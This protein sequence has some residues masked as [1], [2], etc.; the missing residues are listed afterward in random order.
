M[1]TNAKVG[2][3][4]TRDV[5]AYLRSAFADVCAQPLPSIFDDLLA[6]LGTEV[7]DDE[8]EGESEPLV[9]PRSLSDD[10]FKVEL[11]QVIP[12]LRAFGRSL[13]GSRGVALS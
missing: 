1:T 9:E 6:K 8:D 13:S 7:A 4:A 10:E 5:G 3:A 11:A 2:A 12:H